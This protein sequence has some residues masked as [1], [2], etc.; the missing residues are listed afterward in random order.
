[1]CK[2]PCVETMKV[3]GHDGTRY[4]LSVGGGIRPTEDI[5]HSVYD[6]IKSDLR[7]KYMKQFE[8][9]GNTQE[10]WKEQS[11]E[12]VEIVAER[13]GWKYERIKKK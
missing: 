5:I 11:N 3:V 8:K 10:V 12:I 6:N 4:S 13:F 9:T 2:L 1:M 7:P